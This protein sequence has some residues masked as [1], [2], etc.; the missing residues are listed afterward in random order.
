M[1]QRAR[2]NEDKQNAG[3]FLLLRIKSQK[4]II[5]MHEFFMITIDPW[6]QFTVLFSVLTLG[7]AFASIGS[8]LSIKKHL[9]V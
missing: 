9:Q 4:Y 6:A 5:K 2:G 8:F 7:V 1:K 3:H